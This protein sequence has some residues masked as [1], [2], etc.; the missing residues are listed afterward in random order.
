MNLNIRQKALDLG[1][2]GSLSLGRKFPTIFKIT[3]DQGGFGG[4]VLEINS[5][6]TAASMGQAM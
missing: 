3:E 6:H 5:N 2:I 1:I 4:K